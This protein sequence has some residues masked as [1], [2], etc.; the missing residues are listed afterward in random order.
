M[1]LIAKRRSK[2]KSS[3]VYLNLA[4]M[5]DIFTLLVF[6]LLVNTGQAELLSPPPELKLPVSIAQTPPD[7]HLVVSITA[8]GVKVA[9]KPVMAMADVLAASDDVLVP[10]REALLVLHSAMAAA[11]PATAVPSAGAA[12]AGNSAT[13]AQT[14]TVMGDKSIPYRVLKRV[15][16][17]C[18]AAAFTEIDL[19]IKQQTP[20]T[21]A[22]RA[23]TT[24]LAAA[25][26]TAGAT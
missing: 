22:P 5:M 15:M 20:V 17:S 7:P 4:A 14:I 8:E 10:L 12:L 19:A 25:A 24:A 26:R 3:G 6:F 11:A 21:A 1:S 23:Q 13:S 18:Q 2:K 16:A 9:G